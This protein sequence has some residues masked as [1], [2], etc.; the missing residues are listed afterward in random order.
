[1]KGSVQMVFAIITLFSVMGAT[2]GPSGT[3]DGFSGLA[4]MTLDDYSP[5]VD[6]A[7]TIEILAIRALDT[8]DTASGA[9]FF[10]TL[11]I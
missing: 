3:T 7:V 11:T 1:M 4:V 9:D 10:V 5:L 2:S 8:I 6:I